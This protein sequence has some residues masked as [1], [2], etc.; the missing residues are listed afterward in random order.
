MN[1]VSS[2]GSL[3]SMDIDK[4]VTLNI[5]SFMLKRDLETENLANLTGL[6]HNALNNRFNGR[7]GWKI[8]EIQQIAAALNT[9][10]DRLIED[11]DFLPT[12]QKL[13]HQEA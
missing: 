13:E 8:S 7:V 4:V 5:K 3:S 10:L 12:P 11:K 2:N 9:D 1:E 6:K